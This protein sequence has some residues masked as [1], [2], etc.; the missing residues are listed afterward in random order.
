ML[1]CVRARPLIRQSIVSAVECVLTKQ[2]TASWEE[3]M[4][5]AVPNRI[6]EARKTRYK[7]RKGVA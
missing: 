5:I 2:T 3:V 4:E 7:R 1:R 6:K